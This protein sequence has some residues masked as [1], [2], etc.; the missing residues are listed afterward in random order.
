MNLLKMLIGLPVLL[1]VLV[2]AFV[3]NDLVTFSL[4]PFAFEV[5][6]SLSVAIVFLFT[7]G[8]V[9]GNIFSWLSH[10]PLR[11]ALRHHKR[12]YKKL[13]KEQQKLLKEMGML[14]EDLEK[15]KEY[16]PQKP[17]F[18]QRFKN[19]FKSKKEAIAE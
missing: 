9:F 15:A 3:N 10:S 18:F 12:Q 11:K 6:V 16:Q 17:T 1:I 13:N 14:H 5:T 19:I 4:W 8:F 2:F 7:F